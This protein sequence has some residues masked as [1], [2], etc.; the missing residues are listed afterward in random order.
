MDDKLQKI[1]DEHKEKDGTLISLMQ[2]I[3]E[4]Y[5]Y[6][7]EEILRE[8]SSELD[9]PISRFY[10]LATFYSCFRLEPMGKQHICVCVGTACHV[11]GAPLVVDTIERELGMKSGETSEDGEYTLDAVN[12]V[13]ACALGPL[14]T[15][16][17]EFHGHMDQKKVKKLLKE[18][19][20][21][22]K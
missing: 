15:I 3:N 20:T 6:L 2:D 13:G 14:V 12:C 8:V 22:V 1:L 17:G 19:K 7:P 16:D 4:G 11:R 21:A 18:E 9:I 10:S 5:N